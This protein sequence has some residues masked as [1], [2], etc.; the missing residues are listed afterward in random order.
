MQPDNEETRGSADPIFQFVRAAFGLERMCGD[1]EVAF[2][3][4]MKFAQTLDPRNQRA[5]LLEARQAVGL[6]VEDCRQSH[7][8]LIREV[9]RVL[10]FLEEEIDRDQSNKAP[11]RDLNEMMERLA[12]QF[13]KI[14]GQ[15]QIA[16]MPTLATST[17]TVQVQSSYKE[18]SST[19]LI[20]GDM[21][22]AFESSLDSNLGNL[23]TRRENAKSAKGDIDK[24]RKLRIGGKKDA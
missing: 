10:K 3:W 4:V 23:N 19:Q 8:A 15:H 14:V 6:A 2:Q 22:R 18:A 21:D 17:P 7:S 1:L 12:A 13:N 20:A 9:P 11:D 24:L 5:F 16:A